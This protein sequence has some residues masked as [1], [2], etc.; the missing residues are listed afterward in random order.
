MV[1]RILIAYHFHVLQNILLLLI[2]FLIHLRMSKTILTSELYKN[3][4]A[5]MFGP[6]QK[7]VDPE[8]SYQL[9]MKAKRAYFQTQKG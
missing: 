1:I 7:L 9:S 4:T 8:L 3:R 2:F 6:W 5:A